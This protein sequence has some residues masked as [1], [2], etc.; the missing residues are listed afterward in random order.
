LQV[1]DEGKHKTVSITQFYPLFCACI[2][3]GLY[4]AKVG[5]VEKRVTALKVGG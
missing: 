5:G 2:K 3:L 4:A 1:T